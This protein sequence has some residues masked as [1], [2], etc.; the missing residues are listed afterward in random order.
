MVTA[1]ADTAVAAAAMAAVRGP[2][3][4]SDRAGERCCRV[5]RRSS[6][7]G[8]C[9]SDGTVPTMYTY[10]CGVATAVAAGSRLGYDG[11]SCLHVARWGLCGGDLQ[12]AM[13]A[14]AAAAMV[15]AAVEA[16][17][18]VA[19][20]MVVEEEA[21]VAE[22]VAVVAVADGRSDPATGIAPPATTTTLRADSSATG[23]RRPSPLEVRLRRGHCTSHNILWCTV[24]WRWNGWLLSMLR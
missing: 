6:A 15:A 20:A 11:L 5:D 4:S 12:A 21:M 1:A 9:A 3:M 18:V 16:T 22:A 10:P 23:A 7:L 19:E 24:L 14:A 8:P 17:A 2:L 13:A